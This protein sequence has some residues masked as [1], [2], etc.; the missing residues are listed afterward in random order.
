MEAF[1]SLGWSPLS[2]V[3]LRTLIYAYRLI[4]LLKDSIYLNRN[5]LSIIGRIETVH[6]SKN[7]GH[8]GNNKVFRREL[9]HKDEP[10]NHDICIHS[11]ETP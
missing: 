9:A 2:N 11:H 3:S 7:I 4:I 1:R 10:E 6:A 5:D 8:R